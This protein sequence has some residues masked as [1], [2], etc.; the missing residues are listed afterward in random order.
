M[1]LDQV[2]LPDPVLDAIIA[3]RNENRELREIVTQLQREIEHD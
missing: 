1:D 3:L 2:N